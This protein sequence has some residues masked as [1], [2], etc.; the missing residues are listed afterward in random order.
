M[1]KPSSEKQQYVC[2]MVPIR[3]V[4]V[5]PRMMVPFVIGRKSS[6]LA[7]EEA[8]QGEKQI[9]LATQMDA[10]EDDPAPDRIFSVGTV[11]SIVQSLKLPDGNIRVLVEG[12]RRART[13]RVTHQKAFLVAEV[14]TFPLVTGSEAKINV[15]NK[16]LHNLFEQYSK[17]DPNVNYEAIVQVIQNS[18]NDRLSDSVAANLPISVEEKQSLLEI[19][20]PVIR[21][22]KICDLIEVEIEKVKMDRSIQG[23][24]RTQMEKAQREYYLNEKIKAIQ[25][26]LGRNDKDEI[27]EIKEKVEEAKLPPDALEKA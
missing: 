12:L 22:E 18:E 10:T 1:T 11:A 2:P 15:L 3:D 19:S 21:M 25:K 13:I 6:V 4:V 5:F 16:K 27:E 7:L 24:V 20:D 14:E 9:Y 26:E 23:R 17:L 8:L